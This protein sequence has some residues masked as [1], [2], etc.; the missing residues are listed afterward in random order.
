MAGAKAESA[1][2]RAFHEW[3]FKLLLWMHIL[4]KIDLR[5]LHSC[6]LVR[7]LVVALLSTSQTVPPLSPV[8]NISLLPRI[9]FVAHPNWNMHFLSNAFDF[10]MLHDRAIAFVVQQACS[11]LRQRY[12][13]QVSRSL[14]G[15]RN[16]HALGIPTHFLNDLGRCVYVGESCHAWKPRLSCS[17]GAPCTKSS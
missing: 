12:L 3:S 5:C 14:S 9:R 8:Q 2:F 7:L 10:E 13:L 17:K 1:S 6:N 15:A 4:V 11:G 16:G